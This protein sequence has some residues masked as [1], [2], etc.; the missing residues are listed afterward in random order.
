MRRISSAYPPPANASAAWASLNAGPGFSAAGR[1]NL[2]Y[3][4]P[5]SG[6]T[7]AVYLHAPHEGGA[8]GEGADVLLY[9]GGPDVVLIKSDGVFGSSGG[10][11]EEGLVPG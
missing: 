6:L 11:L 2:K 9:H 1:G 10:E 5:G 4:V 3:L 7:V 8:V